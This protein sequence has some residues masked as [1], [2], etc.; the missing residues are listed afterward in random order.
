MNVWMKRSLILLAVLV[1]VFAWTIYFHNKSVSDK[2]PKWKWMQASIAALGEKSAETAPVDED[3]D[4]TRNEIPVHTAHVEIRTMHQYLSGFGTVAPRLARP[5]QM[6][7][8]A[9]LASPVAGVVAQ[10]LCQIGQQIHA[11]EAVIQLDDRLTKSAEEQAAAALAQAQA[12]LAALKAT[13]RPDQLQI[14]QLTVEKSQSALQ[15]SEKNYD[16]L[17]QLATEQGTSGKS[18]EQAA[19]ELAAT[20]TDVAVSQK[21]LALLKSSPT[22]EELHQEEA[23]VAQA[24][25]A[26]AT[27]RMQRQMM[28]I[29]SPI[30]ATV[31]AVTVNPGE[32]VD[33]TKT[34]VQLVAMDRLMVD[35]GVPADQLPANADG[36][37]AQILSSSTTR[38]G[39]SDSALLGKVA[40]VSPQVDAKNGSVV[41]G[42]DLPPGTALRPGLTVRVRIITE[43]HKGVLVVPREAVVSDENGDSVISLLEKDQATHKTVKAGL[44][45][46]GYIEISADGVKE[47]DAIVTGGVFGLPAATRVKVLD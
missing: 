29:I 38:S 31:V 26:L 22:P 8:A 17:K 19:M 35:I 9:N 33:I 44:D 1:A 6:A 7:G 10:V 11:K 12:S 16:R 25:A 24:T 3:P 46:D 20:R 4:N 36:L 41:V 30:D 5:G 14:A 42:I 2:L 45:E 13:P 47:G 15:F 43:E 27:A 40:F 21:Q 23:K 34:L 37:I 18:V 32:S 28:T 39:D